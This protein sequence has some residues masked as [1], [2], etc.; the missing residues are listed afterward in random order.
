MPKEV[1]QE[2]NKPPEGVPTPTPIPL[3][4][5]TP[6]EPTPTTSEGSIDIDAILLPKT[7]APKSTIRVNAGVLLAQEQSAALPT[8]P[9]EKTAP[10]PPA[11]SPSDEKET[12]SLQ[13]FKGDIEKVVRGGQMSI[14]SIAAAEAERRNN[15]PQTED[16]EEGDTLSSRIGSFLRRGVMVVIGIAL[17]ASSLGALYYIYQRPTAVTVQTITP[18]TSF[19]SIDNATSVLF[20][21]GESRDAF[22]KNL[23]GAK[24]SVA[25]SI[26][27]M[28]QLYPVRAVSATSTQVIPLSTQDFMTI[29]APN[30]PNEI[31]RALQP[32]FVL[33]VHAYAENQPF[34]ILSVDT[35]AQAY[36]A[37]VAW[38]PY[39]RQDLGSL[40]A[41]TPRPRI[42][43][44]GVATTSDTIVS[45]VGV[46]SDMVVENRDARVIKNE[47]GDIILLWTFIDRTTI[48]ITTNKYTLREIL[49]RSKITPIVRQ[50]G[51]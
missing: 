51:L 4:N 45:P 38:E 39:M 24:N 27:L 26:G 33:G 32:E 18:P 36:A 2:N 6:A 9:V 48:V 12:H 10:L 11:P 35:Y 19:I 5:P 29:L 22:I 34:L 16:S 44:E 8:T 46:F 37:M 13:T 41:Y 15:T 20:A 47:A 50:P 30:I 14:L 25:L 3:A 43:E 40:F 28:E 23:T 21:I 31:V 17:I 42:P 49:S 1:P 7:E